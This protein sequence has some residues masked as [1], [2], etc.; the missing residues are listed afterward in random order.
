MYHLEAQ[1]GCQASYEAGPEPK[2]TARV[3]WV[4]GHTGVDDEEHRGSDKADQLATI[5]KNKQRDNAH[6]VE[7]DKA[8]L[9]SFIARLSTAIHISKEVLRHPEAPHRKK[10]DC[11]RPVQLRTDRATV[12]SLFPTPRWKDFVTKW[13]PPPV[14]GLT[15]LVE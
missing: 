10:E 5:G 4:K 7:E 12:G 2:G 15:Q 3:V 6:E 13:A 14:E 11:D 1:W 8:T 9:D